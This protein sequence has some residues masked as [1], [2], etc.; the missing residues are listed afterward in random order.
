MDKDT[1]KAIGLPTTWWGD[2]PLF[3]LDD[4]FKFIEYSNSHC[5]GILGIEGFRLE[6]KCRIPDMNCIADF[7]S[8]YQHTNKI[9]SSTKSNTAAKTFLE[10]IAADSDLYFEFT[11]VSQMTKPLD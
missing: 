5:L 8:V 3:N 11:V 9:E 10:K 1:L 2:I 4:S 6:N 7:S